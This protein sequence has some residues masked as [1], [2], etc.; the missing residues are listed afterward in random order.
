M[1]EFLRPLARITAA[2]ALLERVVVPLSVFD[3][4][5]AFFVDPPLNR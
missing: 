2:E 4:R 1:T 3:E 5:G